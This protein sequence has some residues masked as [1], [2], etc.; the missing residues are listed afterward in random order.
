MS[1]EYT[2]EEITEQFISYVRE[3]INRWDSKKNKTSKEKL[4]GFA[5][6]LLST[7]DGTHLELPPFILAPNP[8][9]EDKQFHIDNGKKYYPENRNVKYDISGSLHEIL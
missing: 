7:I 3:L 5:F 2:K 4:N 1:R 6:S 8:H 9:K